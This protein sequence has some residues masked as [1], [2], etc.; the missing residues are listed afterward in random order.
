MVCKLKEK[1]KELLKK[2]VN[3]TCEN[4]HKKK[5]SKKLEIHRIIRGIKGGTYCPHNILIL[6]KDCHELV[7]WKEFR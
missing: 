2:M 6:C 5:E 1:E 3:Y 4:C 7:H